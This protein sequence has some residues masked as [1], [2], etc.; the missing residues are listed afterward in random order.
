MTQ[1]LPLHDLY[2]DYLILN[3]GAATA[4]GLSAMIEGQVSHDAITRCL[5]KDDYGSAQLWQAV[6][7]LVRALDPKN[8][9]LIFDDTLDERPCL[10]SSPSV[11]YHYDHCRGRNLQGINQLNAL[12]WFQ[13]VRLPVADESDQTSS[14]RGGPGWQVEQLHKS[15]T[16]KAGYGQWPAHRVGW[17]KTHIFLWMLFYVKLES[18]KSRTQPTHFAIEK[19]LTLAAL[20]VGYRHWQD[21]KTL[22][23]PSLKAA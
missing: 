3:Q 7:P 21:M 4:V 8:A 6:R 5:H 2:P 12:C 15:T 20:K 22:L 9:F 11:P 14:Q 17:Q 13:S 23:N 18:I 10:Q 19:I 16:S 1:I